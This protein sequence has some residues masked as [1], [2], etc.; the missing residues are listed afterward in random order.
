M[1]SNHIGARI[2]DV[3]A[4]AHSFSVFSLIFLLLLLT[5]LCADFFAL[6]FLYF[7][8]TK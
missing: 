7:I 5:F 8:F 6:A 4:Y 1:K 3:P 2:N